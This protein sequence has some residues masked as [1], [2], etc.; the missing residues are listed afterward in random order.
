MTRHIENFK[1]GCQ[2]YEFLSLKF[3]LAIF[4]ET[5]TIGEKITM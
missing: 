5:G 2:E 4:V 1:I 3:L